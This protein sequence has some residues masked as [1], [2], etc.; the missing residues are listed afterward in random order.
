MKDGEIMA[1]VSDAGTPGMTG[2][3]GTM[4]DLGGGAGAEPGS[5]GKGAGPVDNRNPNA[6]FGLATGGG[7]CACRIGPERTQRSWLFGFGFGFA[8]FGVARLR[9]SRRGARR[10]A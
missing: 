5:A 3:A 2:D 9:R 1:L 6:K 10:A 8:L 7:G 4:G